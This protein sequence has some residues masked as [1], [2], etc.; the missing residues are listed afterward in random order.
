MIEPCIPADEA[1]RLTALRTLDIL[2]TPPEARFDRITRIAQRLFD[3]P[4]ALVSLVDADRQ[5]FKSRAG[6]DA[7]ETP[8]NISFCG[9]AILDQAVF[10]VPDASLDPRFAD[11]PLV[12]TAP[13]IRLYA[14][15]PLAV[16]DGHRVGTLCVID[17]R[18]REFSDDELQALR[19]LADLVQDELQSMRLS[20]ALATV[21][22]H[23]LRLR[24][25]LDNIPEGVVTLS[26]DGTIL[27]ANPSVER[28]FGYTG[29][30]LAG[31]SVATLF[32]DPLQEKCMAGFA[33]WIQTLA[34]TKNGRGGDIPGLRANGNEF[35]MYLALSETSF[36]EQPVFIAVMQDITE[37]KRLEHLK[38]EFVSTVSHELRTPL[39]SIRGSLGLIAGGQAGALPDQAR[40]LVDIAA[41]NSER[42]VRLVND[43]LDV[44]KI[45]SGKLELS[46]AEHDLQSLIEQ[47]VEAN[48]GFADE[49]GVE[50]ELGQKA[51]G[52]HAMVDADR[53]LQIVT[54][55]LSN[56]IK[57][58]SKGE[59]VRLDMT[60]RGD[61]V[62][63]A[64]TD[65]G[66]GVPEAFRGQLFE[67]F[68]QADESNTRSNGGTGLGLSIAKA[69]VDR[70]KGH[71]DFTTSPQGSTFYFELPITTVTDLS[72]DTL[73]AAPAR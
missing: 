16:T 50:I 71:I 21:R 29:A 44:D 4:I 33:D 40:Q 32:A 41:R 3:V 43:I 54:N 15:A 36:R 8:R 49:F 73:Q 55:L 59:P 7:T 52:V 61:T 24:A 64:V 1:Q 11:N 35:P 6:L 53:F 57:V 47:A 30:Q 48:Q 39:T 51:A 37:R 68:T 26:R 9:H 65:R 45:K 70:L 38:N 69:L 22:D 2:D 72:V 23:E 10:Y 5:W 19:D 67:R 46:L 12:T 25:I 27:S 18:P 28:L 63:I 62:R 58:S 20:S 66:P 17:N 60:Q 31:K 56:A 34:S 42:L 14:G 13:D